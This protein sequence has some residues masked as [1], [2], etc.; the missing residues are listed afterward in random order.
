MSEELKQEAHN[1]D[2]PEYNENLNSRLQLGMY[3]PVVRRYQHRAE[4]ICYRTL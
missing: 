4:A 1:K 2:I 3:P